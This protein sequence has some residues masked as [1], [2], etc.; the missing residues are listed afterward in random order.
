MHLFIMEV[1]MRSIKRIKKELLRDSLRLAGMAY[2]SIG[3]N[4]VQKIEEFETSILKDFDNPL[5]RW[6]GLFE[7]EQLLGSMVLYDFDINYYGNRIE[8]QGI[9]FV[10]VDFL[11]KKQKVCKDMLEWYLLNAQ[12]EKKV[13]ALLYSFRPDFYAKM[14]FG[15]G[16]T[17]Y[18]YKFSPQSFPAFQTNLKCEYLN[19]SHKNE[20]VDFFNEHYLNNHGVIPKTE[21]DFQAMFTAPNNTLIGFRENDR[22][23]GFLNF[24]FTTDPNNH[25]ETDMHATLF[26]LNSTGL[27]AILNF[28]NTQADQVRY[29]HLYNQEENFYYLMKDIRNQDLKLLQQPAFHFVSETGMGIMYK[30]LN[31]VQ[32]L[33][34]RPCD[35]SDSRIKFVLSDDFAQE[36]NNEF[37]IEWK[38]SVAKQVKTKKFDIELNMSIRS[39]SSWIMNAIDLSTLFEYGLLETPQADKIL[40]LD[41]AFYYNQKPVCF[42]RF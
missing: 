3:L 13:M 19:Q 8:A 32:L 7:D 2:P 20:L 22:L 34:K 30:S 9:G 6:Y 35:L 1:N 36:K 17:C 10:A 27:K 5:R 15:F 28:L 40:L 14:G 21:K 26:Y 12:K 41:K 24:Y 39:F 31:S 37:I 42:T 16:T 4:N 18:N 38:N 23:L 11:H 33:L 29:I 25:E